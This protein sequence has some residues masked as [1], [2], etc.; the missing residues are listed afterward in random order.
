MWCTSESAESILV[1]GVL[2]TT[3]SIRRQQQ[4][5][6]RYR[7]GAMA[8][9]LCVVIAVTTSILVFAFT[10]TRESAPS[11]PFLVF[12]ALWAWAGYRLRR[13]DRGGLAVGLAALSVAVLI[14]NAVL[15]LSILSTG[16]TVHY[17]ASSLIQLLVPAIGG[18]GVSLAL[19]R[20][21]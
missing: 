8:A 20:N 14:A 11:G 13:Y 12:A 4:D 10:Q 16:G 21:P 5:V 9:A 19:R 2:M 6:P 15:V 1:L 18:I 17:T 3:V 7:A